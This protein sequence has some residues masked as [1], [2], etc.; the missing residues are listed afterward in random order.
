MNVKIQKLTPALAEDY[1]YF[2]DTTS[3]NHS[4]Y[5]KCGFVVHAEQNDKIVVRKALK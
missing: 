3:H 1:A 5:K 4:G 2:F